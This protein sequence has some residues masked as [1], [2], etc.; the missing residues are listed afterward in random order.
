MNQFMSPL[1]QLID[2]KNYMSHAHL[3]IDRHIQNHHRRSLLVTK[4]LINQLKDIK[5]GTKTK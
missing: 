3:R 2:N 4:R 1:K 5:I